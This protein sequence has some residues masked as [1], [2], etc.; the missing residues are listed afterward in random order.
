[1]PPCDE[2][3]GIAANAWWGCGTVDGSSNTRPGD[4]GPDSGACLT[5][6]P[7]NVGRAETRRPQLGL[8]GITLSETPGGET[9]TVVVENSGPTDA[10]DLDL[11]VTLPAELSYLT[12]TSRL[13]RRC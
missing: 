3:L 9:M 5:S 4:P 8:S 1:M 7:V 11:D 6:V 12:G 2:D 13:L 10:F